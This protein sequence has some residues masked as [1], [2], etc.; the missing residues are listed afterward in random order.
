MAG[1]ASDPVV[2]IPLASCALRA[3]CDEAA[4]LEKSW[5]QWRALRGAGVKSSAPP[6]KKRCWATL[7]TNQAYVSGVKA[8]LNSLSEHC[9]SD[10]RLLIMVTDGVPE[11]TR[12]ELAALADSDVLLVPWVAC[13]HGTAA[14]MAPQFTECWTKLRV[15]ELEEYDR[16]VLL[17]ADMVVVRNIDSLLDDDGG[18]MTCGRD[19]GD[20]GGG[21]FGTAA[22][23]FV[24]AVHECS[25]VVKRGD[26]GWPCAH[27]CGS[28][29]HLTP[30]RTSELSYFNSGLL[31]LKPSRLVFEHMLVALAATD[32]ARCPF[33]DQDFLNGYFRN[34]WA[35]LPWVFNATKGLYASH[36]TAD[37]TGKPAVWDAQR[38]RNIHYTM[39]KPWDLKSPFHKGY[40]QLNE[41]WWAAY[42]EPR[43]LS[44]VLLKLR[45]HEKRAA[46]TPPPPPAAHATAA[47]PVQ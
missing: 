1:R 12:A 25:C 34:A 32:L 6:Q 20:D 14:Y 47:L 8:L 43:T 19:D 5:L 26:A 10:Y 31:V 2:P 4:C 22:S 23:C 41:L 3:Q 15:W 40:E 7:L 28:A 42:S 17:D 45:M 36:R 27:T 38:V 11:G 33:A 35:A 39:A 44:R 18:D 21:G 29:D 13:P 30:Q 16:I 46:S 9:E 37:C 24:R